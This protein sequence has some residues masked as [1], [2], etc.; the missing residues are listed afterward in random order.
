MRCGYQ[1]W[2]KTTQVDNEEVT[3]E[4]Q[5]KVTLEDV[6]DEE[7]YL[8]GD[9]EM[10]K[11]GEEESM[12]IY[13]SK[14]EKRYLMEEHKVRETQGVREDEPMKGELEKK[15]VLKIVRE[16]VSRFKEKANE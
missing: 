16:A 1:G 3:V 14:E 2:F 8:I 10:N 13:L 4:F 15:I 6:K 5:E 7:K 12:A 11:K 9:K